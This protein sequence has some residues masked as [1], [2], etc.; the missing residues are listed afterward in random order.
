MTQPVSGK[1]YL[2]DLAQE[3]IAYRMMLSTMS[4]GAFEYQKKV[5][6][7]LDGGVAGFL[8]DFALG[9]EER[10]RNLVR[11][12][13][14]EKLPTASQE[15]IDKIISILPK[16]V[17]FNSEAVGGMKVSHARRHKIDIPVEQIMY[18]ISKRL[19]KRIDVYR[20]HQ[21]YA[22]ETIYIK[23]IG[24]IEVTL[25]QHSDDVFTT[26]SSVR[27]KDFYIWNCRDSGIVYLDRYNEISRP[28][29]V[30]IMPLGL[31]LSVY[32][33]GSGDEERSPA[34]FKKD[35]ETAIVWLVDNVLNPLL[36]SPAPKT[37]IDVPEMEV[38]F[39]DH[40]FDHLY[41][42]APE[43]DIEKIAVLQQNGLQSAYPDERTAIHPSYR[44]IPLGHNTKGLPKEV[45]DGFIWC[46]IGKA[47]EVAQSKN[48]Q[49]AKRDRDNWSLFSKEGIVEVKPLT[50]TDIFVIDWFAWEDFR[51][52]AFTGNKDRLSDKEV[53]DM[54]RAVGATLVPIT[55]YKRTYKK[56]IVMIARNLEVAEIG[57]MFT[58]QD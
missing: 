49:I 46:G 20:Y 2:E 15:D 54:Y 43:S 11:W 39:P 5:H 3:Y 26:I 6:S 57:K 4:Q 31:K 44:L 32:S 42:F 34:K 24:N 14:G 16:F 48:H 18:E 30:E 41:A 38:P 51:A 13:T 8:A 12:K 50:A 17:V 45:H 1:K 55:E 21:N 19:P 47:E 58:F 27:G 23:G 35:Q 7:G 10:R 33:D 36:K 9:F 56:P 22:K 37:Q 40:L 53:D 52:K 28:S 29:S 25:W